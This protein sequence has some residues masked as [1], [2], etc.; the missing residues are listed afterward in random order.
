MRRATKQRRKESSGFLRAI[1]TGQE[2]DSGEVYHPPHNLLIYSARGVFYYIVLFVWLSLL[3]R[4]TGSTFPSPTADAVHSLPPSR[5][6]NMKAT[7]VLHIIHSFSLVFNL[8]SGT[9]RR[10]FSP[11]SLPWVWVEKTQMTSSSWALEPDCLL[12]RSQ[13]S[14]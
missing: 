13:Q 6:Y 5:R 11:V 10:M 7:G 14:G 4:F 12:A 1:P 9:P 2:A 3:S 8:G